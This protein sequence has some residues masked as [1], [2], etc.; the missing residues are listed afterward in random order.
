MT[1]HVASDEILLIRSKNERILGGSLVAE[2]TCEA[3]EAV[4]QTGV[5]LGR[6]RTEGG[7]LY[8]GHLLCCSQGRGGGVD[9]DHAYYNASVFLLTFSPPFS[10]S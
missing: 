4:T 5:E 10:S 3:E 1:K 7:C 8:A 2:A 9:M 6:G